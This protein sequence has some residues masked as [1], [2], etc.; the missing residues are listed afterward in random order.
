MGP[1]F[2]AIT[3]QDPVREMLKIRLNLNSIR[4]RRTAAVK[5]ADR[6]RGIADAKILDIYGDRLVVAGGDIINWPS[7]KSSRAL[8]HSNANKFQVNTSGAFHFL[9]NA[10]VNT[11]TLVAPQLAS[12]IKEIWVV[13][14]PSALPATD[15][16]AA[17]CALTSGGFP[18]V[19][20]LLINTGASAWYGAYTEAKRDGSETNAL[21]TGWHV[22]K[23]YLG[24]ASG[25]N[26][27]VV[28]NDPEAP[29]A[30]AWLGDIAFVMP[31]SAQTTAGETASIFAELQ[32]YYGI[33]P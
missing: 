31:C 15:Y 11:K 27:L 6:L 26:T 8:T 5:L 33:T 9:T 23:R 4:V 17:A 10:T 32:A 14:R 16:R 22:Y 1:G 18:V 3:Y 19:R 7:L 29:T 24:S 21:A 13:A 12:D 2:Y 30:R 20:H 25:C 28:G